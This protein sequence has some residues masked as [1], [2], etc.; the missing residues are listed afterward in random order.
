ME[1]TKATPA[2][3]RDGTWGARVQGTATPGTEIEVTTKSGK[4]WRATV[5][6]V[7]WT[8]DGI[9]LCA[10]Q[11]LDRAQNSEDGRPTYR[12]R[13]YGRRCPTG[14]NCSSFAGY[15]CGSC[16]ECG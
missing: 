15:E 6:R 14:G 8:G 13:P 16:P 9:T 5:T 4:T 7:L 11:S 10:T 12:G 2:K 3:L 1:I